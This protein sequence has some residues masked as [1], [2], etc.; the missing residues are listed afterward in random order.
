LREQQRPRTHGGKIALLS[1]LS[2][3][4]FAQTGAVVQT[5]AISG[6]IVD[7]FGEP[8]S[9]ATVQTKVA[10]KRFETTSTA[11]GEY[12]IDKLP[13]GT[14]EVT[15][16][17]LTMKRLVKK[18][19]VAAGTSRLDVTL[20][21][22]GEVR[23]GTLGD[24]DRF[25]EAA[26]LQVGSSPPSGPVPQLPDGKPDLS[27]FWAPAPAAGPTPHAHSR[28]LKLLP[29][30]QA[31]LR[32]RLANLFRDQPAARCLPSSIIDWSGHGKFVHTSTMLVI[33]SPWGDPPRQVFLDGREHPKDLNPTW[34][35]HSIGHWEGD[36]LVVDTVGFN[37]QTWY[38]GVL[39]SSETLHVIERYHRTDLGHLETELTISD[40]SVSRNP[41]TRRLVSNLDSKEDIEEYICTENNKDPEH[42]VGK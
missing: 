26:K 36:T 7:E 20:V 28:P 31:V 2:F 30:A 42:M 10:G 23:L 39:P 38:Q 40:P 25:T 6:K 27:G 9:G 21:N 4:A 41:W 8:V 15:V 13:R 32:E 24:G 35:G 14:Y 5:G 16:T 3:S 12:A 1:L 34:L 11:T 17:A 22:E 18:C 37:T 29:S 19:S 33:L